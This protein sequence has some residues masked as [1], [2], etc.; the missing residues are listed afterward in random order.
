LITS[1][2]IVRNRKQYLA[3]FFL[4]CVCVYCFKSYTEEIFSPLSQH[5]SWTG[6]SVSVLAELG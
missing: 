4:L 3:V 2:A 6:K 1:S 5:L